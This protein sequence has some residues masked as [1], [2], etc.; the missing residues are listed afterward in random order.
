MSA[1]F[2][3]RTFPILLTTLFYVWAA[4]E[5]YYAFHTRRL[6][7]TVIA[8][9]RDRGS[10]WIILVIVWGSIAG[11][12]FARRHDLGAFRNDLQYFGLGITALG[13]GLRDWA[14]MT[15]GRFFT[16][17]VM[18]ATNQTVVKSGP[19][20][21]LRHPA[22]TGSI[23]TLVGF[24]LALGTWV[25]ALFVFLLT[26]GGFLYRVR[27]EEKALLETLGADYCDYMQHTWRF[28]PGL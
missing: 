19:Y 16:M 12:I 5:L 24:P 28:F 18:V 3:D 27:V 4:S 10:Y 13:I 22:Y 17:T 9:R 21:R 14:V 6:R 23:L 26:V 1:W 2:P 8:Q 20:R 7:R 15:L 25:G 11:S